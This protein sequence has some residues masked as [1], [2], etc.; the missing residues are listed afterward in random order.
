MINELSLALMFEA[1]HFSDCTS[2]TDAISDDKMCHAIISDGA[3]GEDQTIDTLRQIKSVHPLVPIIVIG[4]KKEIPAAVKVM[5]EG[6]SN[7]IPH[8]AD[9]EVL[10]SAIKEEFENG[11]FSPKFMTEPLSR[12]EVHVLKMVA[13]G[14][15]N[16]E[17]ASALNRSVRSI[18]YYRTHLMSK[19]QVN[20]IA[21]L[22]RKAIRFGLTS[23][24]S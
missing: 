24:N 6:A 9:Q 19:L 5:Q 3:S 11:F 13:D 23:I 7:Y 18:E 21:E 20:S 4:E 10:S 12:T 1:V 16:T 17:I 14:N 8:P 22:T 2:C 15:S